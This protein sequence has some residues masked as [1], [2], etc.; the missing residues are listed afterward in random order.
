MHLILKCL[1]ALA[2]LPF[3]LRRTPQPRLIMT[4]LVKNE[5]ARLERNLLFHQR[6]GVD[7]FIVT[8]NNSTD[9]TA[10]II[11]K[12]QACGL[13]LDVI[14]EP[15]TDYAQKQWVDRMVELARTRHQATWVINADADEFW[16]APSGSL[17]TSLSQTRAASIT[18]P[19]YNMYPEEGRPW[20]A[21]TQ[22][23]RP[24][25]D[26]SR[27]HL[28]PYAIFERP[29]GKVMHR[30]RGYVQIS[31]GNHKVTMFPHLKGTAEVCIY[32][33]PCLGHDAF[34][35]KMVNGG[36]QL[37]QHKGRHGGRHWRYYYRLYKEG[38]LEEEYTHVV[39]SD[40]YA[41]L[42]AEHYI[43]RDDTLAEA[44]RAIDKKRQ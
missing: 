36:R 21:W 16:Y 40:C 30:V 7:G 6:M 41:A 9:G 13:I 25:P 38:R 14:H 35:A 1:R 4:L 34:I 26:F 42:V 2:D 33:F 32:H 44:M 19:V 17:K 22:R 8:D 18:V 29:R 20:Y 27:F 12:Y 23:C 15:G 31:M 3:T 5:E 39:G 10:A 37:E 28:S 24:V 43:V 11:R